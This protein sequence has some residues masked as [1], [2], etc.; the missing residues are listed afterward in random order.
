MIRSR[1]CKPLNTT[2]LSNYKNGNIQKCKAA[3]RKLPRTFKYPRNGVKLADPSSVDG[4]VKINLLEALKA[5][6][7]IKSEFDSL[8]KIC[9]AL[10]SGSQKKEGFSV[11]KNGLSLTE[12]NQAMIL[13]RV[14][15][16]YN[17]EYFEKFLSDPLFNKAILVAIPYII[18]EEDAKA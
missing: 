7:P 3:I 17:T 12:V 8:E 14:C 11:E 16:L 1:G 2:F 15:Y 13:G 18:A 9:L 6:F 4:K 5:A 10:K